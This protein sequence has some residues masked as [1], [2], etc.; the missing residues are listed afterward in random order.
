MPKDGY[1]GLT[2]RRFAVGSHY[3]KDG[4]RCNCVAPAVTETPLLDSRLTDPAV[5]QAMEARVPLGRL[6]R[7]DE[8]AQAALYL[9]SDEA[10][11]TILTVDGGIMAQ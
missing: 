3:A 1:T 4:I 5:R 6:G 9:A 7:P 8:I 10:A 11:W 2:C